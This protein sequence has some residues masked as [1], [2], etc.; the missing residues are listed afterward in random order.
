MWS[1][2]GRWLVR[3][4][5]IKF[6]RQMEELREHVNDLSKDFDS[7]HA[8]VTKLSLMIGDLQVEREKQK[9]RAKELEGV[10]T[11]MKAVFIKQIESFDEGTIEE[12]GFGPIK[13]L[14]QQG[15]LHQV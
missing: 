10:I 8:T 6:W 5:L 3:S 13:K 1:W 15:K 9:M 11:V 4:A 12:L 14:I 2:T 7:L